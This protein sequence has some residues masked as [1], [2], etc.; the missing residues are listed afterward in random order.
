[1]RENKPIG[2]VIRG[3]SRMIGRRTDNCAGR[4]YLDSLTGTNGWI[5]G[6]LAH[7]QGRDIYQ[8]DIEEHFSVRRSTVSRVVTLMEQKGLVVRESVDSDARLK[9]LVLTEKALEIHKSIEASF[10]EVE[11]V[12]A[13]GISDEDMETFLRVAHKMMENLCDGECPPKCHGHR[14]HGGRRK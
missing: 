11:S 4:Q 1:M 14:P 3:L 6:Y 2:F 10:D 12:I 5:I 13:E 8:K 9:K 7:N